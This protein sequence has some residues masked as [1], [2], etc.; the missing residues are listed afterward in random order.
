[1]RRPTLKQKAFIKEYVLGADRGNATEAIYKAGYKVVKR[2]TA[3]VIGSDNLR[4]PVIRGEIER[5][6]AKTGLDEAGT[7]DRLKQ[8]IDAGLGEKATNADSLRG[9]EMVFRL[10]GLLG[11]G[12]QTQ[13][14]SLT[15]QLQG[16]SLK[17]LQE[18]L[19]EIRE[20]GGKYLIGDNQ[21]L[22][23]VAQVQ[24]LGNLANRPAP[25]VDV[26]DNSRGQGG[27]GSGEGRSGKGDPPPPAAD[28]SKVGDVP[29]PNVPPT[30]NS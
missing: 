4:K 30:Q 3:E 12:T 1:M 22:E 21:P 18:M 5:L 28:I 13:E 25:P 7:V 26:A 16:K 14:R 11:E 2:H 17:E 23:E 8:A 27:G 10:K 19:K 20:E 15:I 24:P 9:L 6:L 29:L